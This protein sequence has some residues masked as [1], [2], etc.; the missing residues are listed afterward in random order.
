[1]CVQQSY[2]REQSAIHRNTMKHLTSLIEFLYQ[3]RAL[4]FILTGL[5]GVLLNVLTTWTLTEFVFGVD[6]Y[7]IGYLTGTAVNLCY[8]F[9]LHSI[10]TFGTK[11]DHG[12]RFLSFMLFS[13]L[14]T[15]VQII[16]V[17]LFTEYLGR[18][19]YLPIISLTILGLSAVSFVFFKFTLFKEHGAPVIYA[20]TPR[21]ELRILREGLHRFARIGHAWLSRDRNVLLII[22]V[23]ATLTRLPF[24]AYHNQTM[25]DEFYHANFV[26][27][28]VHELPMF[29]IHP[30]LARI[31]FSDIAKQIPYTKD[32]LIIPF[33]DINTAS[34]ISFDDFPFFQIRFLVALCGIF[35][36]L[37]FY[38]IGRLL[39][40]SPL[41]ALLPA[42][43]IIFDNALLL[44]SRAM[45]PDMLLLLT[46]FIGLAC[47]LQMLRL[48]S[49]KQKILW[50]FLSGLFLGLALSTKW[51][52]L[53]LIGLVMLILMQK[54]FWYHA[55]FILIISITTYF[56]VCVYYLS[57]FPQG[58]KVDP[59]SPAFNVPEIQQL[60]F[61]A[62]NDLS[63][64]IR[65]VPKFN[66]IM[67]HVN[68]NKEISSLMIAA[69]NSLAWPLARSEILFWKS[70]NQTQRIVLHGNDLLWSVVFFLFLF[71]IGWVF[72]TFFSSRKWPIGEVE[73][74]LI[75]GY[76][77]NYIPFFFIQ[78]P[79]YLYHYFTALLFL[80]LLAPLVI[81]RLL[82]CIKILTRDRFI[83][84]AIVSLIGF[85]I[86]INFILLLPTTYGF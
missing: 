83:G 7:M 58:G 29:D 67:M 49:F 24:L 86:L 3:K 37:V 15:I 28:I 46:E 73:T 11:K 44:Y 68:S 50:I 1:M 17:H 45:L 19:Y 6:L 76:V 78:R 42:L 85:L 33:S 56:G 40:Y 81:P 48:R 20:T 47:A 70:D 69:P 79:M 41:T 60:S 36:P 26:S 80:F 51:T 43:F 23:L 57:E 5:T 13:A 14:S 52:A 62:G 65:F 75:A 22:L 34:N 9:L 74:I 82:S 38:A 59:I 55:F 25:F 39:H 32:F 2:E 64:I 27:H 71:E 77:M 4:H 61:P 30:P 54:R 31:I 72:T 63:A 12:K 16:I 10:L 8:N 21:E 35:L 84:I 66:A 53:A 18:N